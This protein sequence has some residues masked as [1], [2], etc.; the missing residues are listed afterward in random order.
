MNT[1][2]SIIVPVYN[3]AKFIKETI[4]SVLNQTYPH[5]ELILV[6]DAS[7]DNSAEVIRAYTDP[8]IHYLEHQTNKGSDAARLTGL[9]AS[10]GELIIFLDQDDFF[11][12]EKLQIH[13]DYFE[14]HPDVGVTYNAR[15]NYDDGIKSILRIWTPPTQL[16]LVDLVMG[17][18]F[19]PSDTVMRRHWAVRE[20]IWDDSFVTQGDEVIVNGGEI[21]FYGRLYLAGCKFADVGKA[22]NYRR[23]H[24]HRVISDIPA[25]CNSERACQEIILNDPRC[26]QTV[27]AHRDQSFVNTYL[28]WAHYAFAQKNP[29]AGRDFIQKAI[30]LKPSLIEGVP[31]ELTRSFV[32]HSVYDSGLNPEDFINYIFS[33][34]PAECNKIQSQRA[35]AT[36]QANLLKGVAA[37]MWGRPEEGQHFM[38]RAAELG[39]QADELFRRKLAYDLLNYEMALGTQATLKTVNDLATSMQK[40]IGW[41]DA[42]RLKGSYALDRAFHNY[43]QGNYALVPANVIKAVSNEPHHL[44]NKGVWSIFF[45]SILK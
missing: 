34:L 32:S 3:G 17:F 2:I 35:W 5:F 41:H 12:P 14:Q 19:A 22:L 7:P 38:A 4:E 40:T 33:H 11:H 36:G 37:I 25:R 16:T 44:L 23:V 8:R 26:P 29:E 15:F 45:R 24:P 13:A 42:R 9:S 43:Q 10:S 20:E 18:P 28:I 27:L 1:L 30:T 31:C 6:N 39:A 21:V